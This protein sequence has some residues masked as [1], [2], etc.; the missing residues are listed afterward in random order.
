MI[1]KKEQ[2]SKFKLYAVTDI[3]GPGVDILERVEAAYRGGADIVQLRVKAADDVQVLAWAKKIR[4]IA[5]AAGKLFFM[6]DRV[7]IALAAGADGVHLGQTDL[8]VAEARA[9]ASRCGAELLVGKST[10]CLEQALAAQDEGVDYIGVGPVF[11]TP[12]K[13]LRSAAGLAYVRD[14]RRAGLR[15]PFVAIGGIDLS[16]ITQVLEAGADRIAC[17]RALFDQEDTCYAATQLRK[18]IEDF[19]HVRS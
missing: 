6:N 2:L 10:H 1:S 16:N 17:V 13:P 12:T 9:L 5:A 4:G 11:A 8:P 3:K 19:N 14:V 7:D 15:I 18:Q